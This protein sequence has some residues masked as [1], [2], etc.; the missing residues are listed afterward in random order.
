MKNIYIR[1]YKQN[2][3]KIQRMK[4]LSIYLY[5]YSQ[6]R[7]KNDNRVQLQYCQWYLNIKLRQR[8]KKIKNFV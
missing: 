3:N 6:K 1:K 5:V 2:I 8:D 4:K 7:K